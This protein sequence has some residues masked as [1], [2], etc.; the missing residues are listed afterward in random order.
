MIEYHGY[1]EGDRFFVFDEGKYLGSGIK[2]TI[3][4]I[5]GI[6]KIFVMEDETK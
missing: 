6:E 2:E 5:L 1:Y 3:L 4:N